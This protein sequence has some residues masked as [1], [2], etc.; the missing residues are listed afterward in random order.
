MARYVNRAPERDFDRR[1]V[2]LLLQIPH[3]DLA[4]FADKAFAKAEYGDDFVDL[5][6]FFLGIGH[7]E[8]AQA[9]LVGLKKALANDGDRQ[10]RAEMAKLYVKDLEE[11]MARNHCKDGDLLKSIAEIGRHARR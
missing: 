9:A 1:A 7:F 2:R 8:K 4:C 10:S 11:T 6:R 5:F 3:P